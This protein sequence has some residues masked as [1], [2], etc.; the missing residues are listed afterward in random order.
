MK[1]S[2]G[3]FERA[4]QHDPSFAQAYA[5]KARAYHALAASSLLAPGDAFEKARAAAEKALELDDTIVDAHL[6]AATVDQYLDHDQARAGLA[7]E[8]AVEL[9]PNSAYAHE[10]YGILYLSPMGRH[11]HAIAE[12]QRA[13]ELDPVAVPWLL[14]L[15]MGL[16]HGA[17]I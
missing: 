12:L 13:V 6:V 17:S 4:L 5:G 8:R 15:G 3:Y 1:N 2:I 7:Y 16:L 10:A 14:D 9:A 11:E